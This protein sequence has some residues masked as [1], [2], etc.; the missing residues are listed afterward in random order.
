MFWVIGYDLF[1]D[2]YCFV[3]DINLRSA[4]LNCKK[5][6]IGDYCF[7]NCTN[8]SLVSSIDASEITYYK[9]SFQK[10]NKRLKLDFREKS[11]KRVFSSSEFLK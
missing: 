4:Q 10:T 9:N 6:K 11:M 5:L 1:L 7:S 3:N 2:N 8:L